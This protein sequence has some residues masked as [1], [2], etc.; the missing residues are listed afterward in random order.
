MDPKWTLTTTT[1]FKS[2]QRID[3]K[4]VIIDKKGVINDK[5][6]VINQ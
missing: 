4:G 1:I 6:G 2:V 5:K 3:K